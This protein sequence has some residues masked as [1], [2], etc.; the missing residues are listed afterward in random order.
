LREFDARGGWGNGFRSCA[1]WLSWRVGLD[2]GAARERVRVARALGELPQ[3]AAALARGE[4]SYAKVR[5]LT[6]V[7]TPDTEARLLAVGRTGTAAHVERIVRAWRRVDR[8]EEVREAE[9]R[10]AGRSLQVYPDEDGM[11]VIRGRLEPEVGAMLLR[12]L[13]AA[14]EALYQRARATATEGHETDPPTPGQQQ[15]DALALVAETAL[16]QG[17]DP[18][19]GSERYQVVVHV[20]AAALA[21]PDQPGQSALEDGLR[22]SGE[23]SRRLA[24]DATRVVMRHANAG[25]GLDVGRRTRTIPPALRRALQARDHGCRFPGCGVR[26]AQGHHIGFARPGRRG[27]SPATPGGAHIHHWANGGPTRLDNLTLLCRRH[28]RAVHE[29]G[30]RVERDAEGTLAFSTPTGRPIWDVPAPPAVP[31]DPTDA[32]VAAH[33]ALGLAIDE[34]TA[35]PSWLGERLDLGWA[36]GVLHPAAS[37]AGVEYRSGRSG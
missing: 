34:E 17:L 26:Y 33:R 12:A 30:Y 9:A 6:R 27:P 18:G 20:D 19:P 31:R 28:H 13:E 24:C 5:A 29:E 21:D 37:V 32:L 10:H 3:L 16:A 11:M 23:T 14:R 1:E 2:P 22:V 8:Q 4:L 25:D 35:C 7:A 15:A 36:I